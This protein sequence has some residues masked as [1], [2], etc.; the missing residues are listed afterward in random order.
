[1]GSVCAQER[2]GFGKGWFVINEPMSNQYLDQLGSEDV[3]GAA[4][5]YCEL[6]WPVFPIH[7]LRNGICTCEKPDCG[8]VAK[9]PY[10]RLVPHGLKDATTDPETVRSW[11]ESRPWLNIAIAT[12]NGLGVLDIDP[13]HSGQVS[14]RKL[15]KDHPE[16]IQAWRT[17]TVEMP[18]VASGGA[19]WH[20]YGQNPS[21]AT[22]RSAMLEGIDFRGNGGYIIAPPSLHRSGQRYRWEHLPTGQLEPFPAPI[23]ALILERGFSQRPTPTTLPIQLAS[24]ELADKAAALGGNWPK[25][26]DQY[27]E[28][29]LSRSAKTMASAP[30]GTHRATLNSV[31]IRLYN[32]QQLGLIS[33]STVRAY[34]TD[35]L[36]SIC[37]KHD[38]RELENSL[39][40]ACTYAYNQPAPRNGF[41]AELIEIDPFIQR[42]EQTKNTSAPKQPRVPTPP[43]NN[44]S[45]ITYVELPSGFGYTQVI[46]PENNIGQSASAM[47]LG[48]TKDEFYNT[49]LEAL[50]NVVQAL[51]DTGMT[52]QIA[53]GNVIGQAKKDFPGPTMRLFQIAA[54]QVGEQVSL[55]PSTHFAKVLS[56]RVI[57]QGRLRLGPQEVKQAA[58][59]YL[60]V[61]GSQDKV[62]STQVE[63][64][65]N[66]D[67]STNNAERKGITMNPQ[68]TKEDAQER[69]SHTTSSNDKAS[70]NPDLFVVLDEKTTSNVGSSHLTEIGGQA[71]DFSRREDVTRANLERQEFLKSAQRGELDAP[72]SDEDVDLVYE[73]PSTGEA[74]SQANHSSP[75]ALAENSTMYYRL[76]TS[77]SNLVFHFTG[78]GLDTDQAV[79]AAYKTLIDA[80]EANREP[81]EALIDA[82]TYRRDGAKQA[83]NSEVKAVLAGFKAVGQEPASLSG[84]LELS[85]RQLARFSAWDNQGRPSEPAPKSVDIEGLLGEVL[86]NEQVQSA[87]IGEPTQIEIMSDQAY[88]AA[89]CALGLSV[90]TIGHDHNMSYNDM[91]Y[92]WIGPQGSQGADGVPSTVEDLAWADRLEKLISSYEEANNLDRN[93]QD[94]KEAS[95][96][97]PNQVQVLNSKTGQD[98]AVMDPAQDLTA[99]SGPRA[100]V[101]RALFSLLGPTQLSNRAYEAGV[102]SLAGSVIGSASNNATAP[103]KVLGAIDDAKGYDLVIEALERAASQRPDGSL[104]NAV[105]DYLWRFS[106]EEIVEVTKGYP[107]ISGEAFATISTWLSYG[108]PLGGDLFGPSADEVLG[109]MGVGPHKEI[110]AEP[111]QS[112]L[113]LDPPDDRSAKD[114]DHLA[115]PILT[116]D[117]Y[118]AVLAACA[119]YGLALYASTYANSGELESASDVAQA[120]IS[121]LSASDSTKE[122]ISALIS[123]EA[124]TRE[125][126]DD[127]AHTYLLLALGE[128]IS[129]TIDSYPQ[130]L[131]APDVV[132]AQVHVAKVFEW[133][134][135]NSPGARPYPNIATRD[136]TIATHLTPVTDILLSGHYPETK[137]DEIIESLSLVAQHLCPT[138][139]MRYA[140][141]TSVVN[142][143]IDV[144]PHLGASLAKAAL[145]RAGTNSSDPITQGSAWLVDAIARRAGLTGSSADEQ[146]AKEIFVQTLAPYASQQALSQV[147]FVV[148]PDGAR[149]QM[150]PMFDL[151][152]DSSQKLSSAEQGELVREMRFGHDVQARL[153]ARTLFGATMAIA[154][155]QI[156]KV[157]AWARDDASQM[158]RNGVIE[159]MATYDATTPA[160][161]TT[162]AHYE[163]ASAIRQVYQDRDPQGATSNLTQVSREAENIPARDDISNPDEQI[164]A[165][166]T[167]AILIQKVRAL[168]KQKAD[169]FLARFAQD[170]SLRDWDELG[171]LLKTSS[172]SAKESWIAIARQLQD[173]VVSERDLLTKGPNTATFTE[174]QLVKN[175]KINQ[176]K[177]TQNQVEEANY[178]QST[179]FGL[180]L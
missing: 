46:D 43:E 164:V 27:V 24:G 170:G 153:A 1:M 149:A 77:Y 151:G 97:D 36:S 26:L 71:D 66:P 168:P 120:A 45:Q 150:V 4:L 92:K 135:D 75:E 86:G 99:K 78:D 100:T 68:T 136:H 89:I 122:A 112:H 98:R 42:V 22:N 138:W 10:A 33:E 134:G 54:S 158:A 55:E 12:G 161:F 114:I 180:S 61:F 9:H 129:E 172:V 108:A 167:K 133:A 110:V 49:R 63:Q 60:Q 91:L 83:I 59:Y 29:I 14:L 73:L 160:S 57:T 8:N 88:E 94:Y 15:A 69:V 104:Y 107:G 155:A 34:S 79:I 19:G 127:Q 18:S 2:E 65:P 106:P 115:E 111:I 125:T 175:S 152:Q 6:G 169:I 20:Y 70:I 28:T 162:W 38:E 157:P 82:A 154:G 25:R 156:A 7:S 5:A 148:D 32:L 84:A 113:T 143:V 137:F 128:S 130:G 41:L 165:N 21:D 64:A 119:T 76:L 53:V 109:S 31:A 177:E 93:N 95:Q 124:I 116:L 132:Q 179:N 139:P 67:L 105:I 141:A 131:C 171:G 74:L 11:F 40:S 3:L 142:E 37:N 51:V 80:N 166:S 159:A 81:I 52:P 47:S 90:A 126:T 147:H 178:V 145:T 62:A 56:S 173:Q 85:S 58:I 140:G 17:M 72:E 48:E 146:T 13:G 39:R 23:R 117:G 101:G 174:G 144:N 176:K 50:V 30:A 102:A 163:V 44:I 121:L 87:S 103:G 35:I 118:E 16:D 96:P 123:V